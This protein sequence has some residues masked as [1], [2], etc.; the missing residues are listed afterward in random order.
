[1]RYRRAT[2]GKLEERAGRSSASNTNPNYGKSQ[3]GVI[4]GIAHQ[5]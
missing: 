5:F 3:F 2:L 1:L 4:T